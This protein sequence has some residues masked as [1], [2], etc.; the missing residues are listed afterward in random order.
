MILSEAKCAI[1]ILR[2]EV[3]GLRFVSESDKH[4][5]ISPNKLMEA[6]TI[7][8]RLAKQSLF[9]SPQSWINFDALSNTVSVLI[10]FRKK[11]ILGITQHLSEQDVIQVEMKTE[12]G[13]S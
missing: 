12:I 2:M 3:S 1:W 13:Q 7:S 6:E 9:L 11:S 10:F 4:L 8:N 5:P